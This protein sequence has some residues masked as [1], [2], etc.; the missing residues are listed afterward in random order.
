[1]TPTTDVEV[2]GTRRSAIL[3]AILDTGFDGDICVPT[4][5]A[6]RLGLELTGR[7]EMALADGTVK[8]GLVF[9]GW[10][11]FLGRKHQVNVHI[12]DSEDTLIG[13]GLLEGC[14][15]AVDFA[16]G[17]VHLSRKPAR[18]RKRRLE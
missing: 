2:I 14:L 8:T 17:K 12:A 13:T 5:I 16:A 11:R 4:T 3:K 9:G 10:V 6:V 1:M 7:M 15:L 18:R